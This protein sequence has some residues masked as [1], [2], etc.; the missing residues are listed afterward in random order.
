M[1]KRLDIQV[2]EKIQVGSRVAISEN[3]YPIYR[4]EVR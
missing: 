1:V 4:R 2:K 3:G